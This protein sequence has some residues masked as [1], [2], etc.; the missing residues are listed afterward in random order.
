MA[1]GA[2][3]AA[4]SAPSIPAVTAATML[5]RAAASIVVACVTATGSTGSAGAVSTR[6]DEET[7]SSCTATDFASDS[8]AAAFPGTG[9]DTAPGDGFRRAA[10]PAVPVCAK[11]GLR[12]SARSRRPAGLEGASA[13]DRPPLGA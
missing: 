7:E 11:S 13:T 12:A 5:S 9:R 4:S 2:A 3:A 6:I 8:A 10:T 1:T